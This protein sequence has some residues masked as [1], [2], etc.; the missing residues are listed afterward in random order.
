MDV[1]HEGKKSKLSLPCGIC[2]KVFHRKSYMMVHMETAHEGKKPFSCEFCDQQY[3]FKI[4]M[5]QHIMRAHSGP[6]F[7]NGEKEILYKLISKK[8]KKSLGLGIVEKFSLSNFF[9]SHFMVFMK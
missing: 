3:V 7:S 1:L 6:V 9:W 2:N 5:K 4:S 8:L